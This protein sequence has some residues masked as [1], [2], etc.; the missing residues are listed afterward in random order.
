MNITDLR[1]AE[2]ECLARLAEK[3]NEADRVVLTIL[4]AE[5]GQF[6]AIRDEWT[7]SYKMVRKPKT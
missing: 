6:K 2:R 1:Q 7:Q 5:I 4:Q 3:E